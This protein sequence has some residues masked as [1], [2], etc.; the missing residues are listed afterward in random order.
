MNLRNTKLIVWHKTKKEK[1]QVLRIDWDTG[2]LDLIRKT[3]DTDKRL[4][5]ESI[6]SVVLAEIIFID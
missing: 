5:Y 2:T 6:D 4:C 3:K 1:Y